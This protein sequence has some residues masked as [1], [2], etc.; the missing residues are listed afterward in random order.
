M[1]LSQFRLALV[2]TA[3]VYFWLKLGRRKAADRHLSLIGLA[4]LAVILF[5][6]ISVSDDLWWL[7]N[8]A[9]TDAASGATTGLLPPLI[10]PVLPPFP[11]SLAGSIGFRRL[12]AWRI[13]RRKL[14]RQPR[15]DLHSESPSALRLILLR[16]N[17]HP[18]SFFLAASTA[19][20]MYEADLPFRVC[21]GCGCIVFL[22]AAVCQAQQSLTWEQV[23]AR[24]EAAN[25][26]LKADA[27]SV[28]E[29]ARRGNDR[30]SCAPIRSSRRD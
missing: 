28:D 30:L 8:P 1:E 17:L 12:A 7:H 24:F 13:P 16:S 21:P 29:T 23:K 20:G 27:V 15:S 2:A 22:L 19:K 6:V 26:A 5:P 11:S 9:E 3:S 4:M 10:F 14:S 25:P 18:L